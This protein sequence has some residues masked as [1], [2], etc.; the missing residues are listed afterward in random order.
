MKNSILFLLFL[1]FLM[2][3]CGSDPCENLNC[4][5]GSCVDGSCQCEEGYAGALCDELACVNG[6]FANGSCQCPQ[7]TYG[8]LCD[9]V[10]LPGTYYIT[11]LLLD[12]C[13]NYVPNYDIKAP[14]EDQ[15]VCGQDESNFLTCF[16]NFI[17]LKSDGSYVWSRGTNVTRTNGE[18]VNVFFDFQLGSY[19]AKNDLLTTTSDR[20][21]VRTATIHK[22]HLEWKRKLTDGGASCQWLE[23][24]S[25]LE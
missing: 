9:N 4:V 8:A 18:V 24:Y 2:S 11:H 21:V 16:L 15:M 3:N 20:G 10:K 13:P 7:G 23:V 6:N 25:R 5:N 1:S 22:D 12:N 14:A 17:I 19:T